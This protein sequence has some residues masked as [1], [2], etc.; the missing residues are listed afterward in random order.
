[1]S[2]HIFQTKKNKMAAL[3][4]VYTLSDSVE[5][6]TFNAGDKVQIH[7]GSFVE[8]TGRGSSWQWKDAQGNRDKSPLKRRKAPGAQTT[9]ASSSS[10]AA[11]PRER[12][13]RRSPVEPKSLLTGYAS[14]DDGGLSI[15]V[16]DFQDA[17][18]SQSATEAT[19]RGSRKRSRA[20]GALVQTFSIAAEDHELPDDYD[21]VKTAQVMT[22]CFHAANSAVTKATAAESTA[23]DAAVKAASAVADLTSLRSEC[24]RQKNEIA[25]WS[26]NIE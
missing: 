9:S 19:L 10:A 23:E 11:N 16:H 24:D 7:D 18:T 17:F 25:R 13:S 21:A 22:D 4:T 2:F 20:S 8:F 14:A 3:P 15:S 12:E 26:K 5:G 1:M 6:V